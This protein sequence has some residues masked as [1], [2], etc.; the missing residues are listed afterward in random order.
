MPTLPKKF[1]F[2]ENPGKLSENPGK[3]SENLGNIPENLGKISENL[4]KIP[5]NPG[6][7]GAQRCL[8][9]KNGAQR[10]HKNTGRPFAGGHTKKRSS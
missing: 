8:T 5:K 9:S 4:G 6:K 10:L 3:I 2:V 1:C 7:N